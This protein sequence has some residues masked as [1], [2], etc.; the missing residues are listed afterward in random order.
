MKFNPLYQFINFARSI[1]LYHNCPTLGQFAGCAV[2]ASVIF[3]LGVIL[4]KKN[5]DKFIYYI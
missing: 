1:I 4:F 2:S 3:V 5:Q